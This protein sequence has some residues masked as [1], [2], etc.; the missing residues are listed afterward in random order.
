MP[1][2]T[3]HDCANNAILNGRDKEQLGLSSQLQRD[4]AMRIVRGYREIAV[5]PEAH[6]QRF[7]AW[8]ED[9]DREVGHSTVAWVTHQSPTLP[10]L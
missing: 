8:L 5:L 4:I 3:H 9:A 1:V 10:S 2:I 7:V 6:D